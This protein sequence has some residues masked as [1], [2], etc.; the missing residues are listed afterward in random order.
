MTGIPTRHLGELAVSSQGLG[1][2]G[3]SHGYGD[4]D[5]E[6][7]IATIHRALDLGVDLLD[8]SDFYGAG[9]NEELIG[10]AIAGHRDRVVLATK[11]GFANRLGEPV[12]IRGDAAYVRQACEASLRRLGADHIDLYYQHRVDPDVPI[13]ETV[14]AMAELVEAGKVRYLGL[15]EASASTIRRAHAVHPISA[16]QSEWSLWTRDLEQEIA[17]VCRELGIGLVPFSPLGRG[18][19]TGRYT[20]VAGLPESDLRRAQPRFADGN[21]EQNL[22]VVERLNKL[23]ADKGVTAG[24]LALAWVQ[25]RG[26]DVVP[27]PGTRRERYLEENLGALSV[28]LTAEELAEID[29]AAPAAQ[30]AGTRYDEVSMTF[31]NR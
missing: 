28:R 19:L 9:H 5:E 8:T 12:V 3:M 14:G 23:A 22:A 6:Q 26:D 31:V 10:R 29:A 20:S 21:L 7:S 11:F 24:Q 15:S 30:I 2:M 16:L 13:E 25:Y 27:I 18:F 17:P 1:C 4:A